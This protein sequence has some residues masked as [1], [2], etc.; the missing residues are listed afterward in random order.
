MD[1]NKNIS[2]KDP[3]EFLTVD[4]V[5]SADEAIRNAVQVEIIPREQSSFGFNDSNINVNNFT[6]AVSDRLRFYINDSSHYLDMRNSYINCEFQAIVLTAGNVNIPDR[7]IDEG[8]IHSSI[9]TV[10]VSIGG[11]VLGRIDDYAKWYNAT[12]NFPMHSSEYRDRILASSGDSS[13]DV[14]SPSVEVI[15]KPISFTQETATLLVDGLLDLGVDGL[16][17]TELQVGDKLVIFSNLRGE[18]EVEVLDIGGNRIVDVIGNGYALGAA[19]ID[20]IVLTK[21]TNQS[22]RKV[23]A[24]GQ[25]HNLSFNLPLGCLQ[26]PEYF[27]LPLIQPFGPLEIDIEFNRAEQVLVLENLSDV[28]GDNKFAYTINRP[29]FIARMIRPGNVINAHKALFNSMG[30]M[31]PYVSWRHFENNIAQGVGDTVLNIQTNLKSA[32]SIVSVATDQ[33]RANSSS[34]T[35]Q[36][37]KSQSTFLR[38]NLGEY[39]YLNG[40]MRMPEYDLVDMKDDRF[41]SQAWQQ[42]M[43]S[44]D[45]YN[46]YSSPSSSIK[47]YQW[48][49]FTSERFVASTPFKKHNSFFTGLDLSNNFLECELNMRNGETRSVSTAYH[50]WISFDSLLVISR[51]NGVRVYR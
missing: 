28:A 30:L 49:G 22:T 1:I 33:T 47:P 15:N 27:P 6:S 11:A 29:R 13:E 16:A 10:T 7:F 3:V 38:D 20:G 9:R 24:N 21:R 5:L 18:Q 12:K 50:S 4:K 46:D 40:A 32:R 48:R 36:N 34:Q 26:L 37:Y 19:E 31:F 25:V 51:A 8:G 17:S 23:V 2:F 39:R 35:A 45:M 42:Y 14:S 43:L 41:A 44:V